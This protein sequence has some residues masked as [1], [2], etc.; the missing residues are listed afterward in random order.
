MSWPGWFSARSLHAPAAVRSA[1][2]RQV[3]ADLDQR[4][5][6]I[7]ARWRGC[8]VDVHAFAVAPGP[9]P[10]R[11]AR[12]PFGRGARPSASP[13]SAAPPAALGV[14]SRTN[15]MSRSPAAASQADGG[16]PPLG[17]GVQRRPNHSVRVTT[18]ARNARLPPAR[19]GSDPTEPARRQI[20]RALATHARAASSRAA[21]SVTLNRPCSSS[22]S[23]ARRRRRS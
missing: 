22:Q 6:R 13:P 4:R 19:T 8:A 1:R 9:T 3:S 18:Q 2:D 16:R 21:G 11:A 20:P 23:N 7:A 10:R 5:C 12:S 17:R 15:R 14:P